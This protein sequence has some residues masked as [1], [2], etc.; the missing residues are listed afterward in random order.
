MNDVMWLKFERF[1]QQLIFTL[2]MLLIRFVL[3]E[4]RQMSW[5]SLIRD[6]STDHEYKEFFD[7]LLQSL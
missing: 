4:N 1:V 3:F 2:T 7:F 5:I 6:N